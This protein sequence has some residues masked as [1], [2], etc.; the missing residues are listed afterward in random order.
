MDMRAEKKA[1]RGFFAHGYLW[2]PLQASIHLNYRMEGYPV[3][4]HLERI[5]HLAVRLIKA[6]NFFRDN[7]GIIKPT[8]FLQN[9]NWPEP[10]HM[11]NSAE[12]PFRLQKKLCIL[13]DIVLLFNFEAFDKDAKSFTSA[14]CGFME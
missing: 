9:K 10:V 5:Q 3:S 1:S 13:W 8:E 4:D 7:A 11:H 12:E 6:L 2:K 14:S